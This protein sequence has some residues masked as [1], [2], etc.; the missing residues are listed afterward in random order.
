VNGK[1][2]KI[3]HFEEWFHIKCVSKFV[4]VRDEDTQLVSTH[5]VKTIEEFVNDLAVAIRKSVV[6]PGAT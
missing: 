4:V 2:G 5:G 6:A 1:L 3:P